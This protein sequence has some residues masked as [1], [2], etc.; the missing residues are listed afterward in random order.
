MFQSHQSLHTDPDPSQ[1]HQGVFSQSLQR[2]LHLNTHKI[3]LYSNHTR[4]DV[5]RSQPVTTH[6]TPIL[7]YQIL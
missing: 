1:Q 6:P 4:S 7:T 5:V 3:Q 2:V